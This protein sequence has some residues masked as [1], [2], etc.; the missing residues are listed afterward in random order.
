MRITDLR[1]MTCRIDAPIRN[2]VID[3]SDM[4]VSLVAIV[5][6]EYRD[7]RPVI[8]Y[9]FNSNGRYG[10]GGLLRER[11]FPRIRRAE[12]ESLLDDA[13]ASFRPRAIVDA[14]MR[15]EKPGGHGER[16]VAVGIVDMAAWDLVGKLAGKPVSQ[17]LND[18]AANRVWTYAAGGYYHPD[19]DIEALRA[20]LLRYV[21]LGYR[22]VKMKIGGAPLAEDMARVEAALDALPPGCRLAVDANG[23]YSPAE[24]LACANALSG[25]DLAWYEEP[26]DPLDYAG[27]AAVADV[28]PG[29]IA[30]G[31]NLL[32][33]QDAENLLRYGGL[34]PDR[35]LLQMDP[36]L[37]YGLTEYLRTID[38]AREHGW[39]PA[40]LLPHGGH[41]FNLHIAAALGLGG[42]EAYPGVFAPFGGFAD[43]ER[44]DAGQ[45]RVPDAP[46]LGLEL[47]PALRPLLDRLAT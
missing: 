26:V 37:S 6:D 8:G 28:Y 41:Q 16:A 14:A 43:G 5:T 18:A 4:T 36:V 22:T 40:G 46:G 20:E 11:I 12:P 32:S 7:G 33:R 3:F 27:L 38:L 21:G 30:T 19:K 23:R 1:E 34:R 29:S 44:V 15:N 42:C 2:A 31:E 10:Q 24:A 17:V 35:D 13:G 39:P 9:G 45:A 25:H 47:K